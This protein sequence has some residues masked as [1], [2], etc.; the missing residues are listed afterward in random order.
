MVVLNFRL[1]PRAIA[2]LVAALPLLSAG[3]GG[4]G[5]TSLAKLATNQDAY[6]GKRVATS[7]V[8][9]LETNANGSHYY[10]L[11]DGAGDLVA[12]EPNGVARRYVG[13]M[14]AV[15]GTFALDPRIGRLITIAR[16]DPSR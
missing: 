8:V 1:R 16:I 9:E 13:R 14:V 3:F 15:R 10:V 2:L 11:T 4:G 5:Q 6:F 7:G 12:L